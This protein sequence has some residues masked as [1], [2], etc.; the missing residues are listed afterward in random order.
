MFKII[1]NTKDLYPNICFG[2][3]TVHN[4]HKNGN[5]ELMN[6]LKD[7]ELK[8]IHTKFA[9]YDR[10]EANKTSPLAEY[11]A[12]Y[13]KFKKTYPVLL[14]LE[15]VV[16]KNKDIPAVGISVEAMFLAEVRNLLLTAG[17]DL[18]KIQGN[19][20]INVADKTMPYM[21]I[22]NHETKVK[23]HDIFAADEQGII[24]SIVGGPDHRTM[25]TPDT[26]NALYFI[27]GVDGITKDQIELHLNT[28]KNYLSQTIPE[29]TFDAIQIV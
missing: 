26:K 4:L 6:K 7:A 9:N 18:D 20:L 15:S 3:L 19:F 10:S 2:A 12:Y 21:G 24:S 17:H 13:K 23:E 29:C 27:Y 14:Q 8:N 11:K 5:Q 25:I 28:I 16:L 22:S 1:N